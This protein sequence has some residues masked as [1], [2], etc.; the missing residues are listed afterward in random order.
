VLA[1]GYAGDALAR[2]LRGGHALV[3][4]LSF[5]ASAPVGLVALFHPSLPVF[6]ALTALAAFLFSIYNGPTAAVVD[7]LGPRAYATTL[8]AMFLLVVT[9]AGNTPAA[10]AIGRLSDVMHGH[11]A[12][13]LA[14]ALVAAM[15]AFLVSGVLFVVVA[16]LQGKLKASFGARHPDP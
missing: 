2:R 3:V 5:L 1:G 6:L 13:P 10:L 8:Q 14:N 9:L 4:G 11:V 15:A 7:E 16:R 12:A